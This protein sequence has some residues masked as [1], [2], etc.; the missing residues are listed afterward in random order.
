MAT[1]STKEQ[2][3]KGKQIA[4][5]CQSKRALLYS[6]GHKETVRT[7]VANICLPSD[8]T[9]PVQSSCAK[10]RYLICLAGEPLILKSVSVGKRLDR[11]RPVPF[12]RTDIGNIQYI[13][14]PRWCCGKYLVFV[15]SVPYEWNTVMRRR[16]LCCN[17]SA[18]LH[19]DGASL[20]HAHLH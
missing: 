17:S 18:H 12:N 8:V 1:I 14:S 11:E 9:T 4:R 7:L 19:L 10:S 13:F 2:L 6:Q 16:R 5:L 15:G 20:E 3:F